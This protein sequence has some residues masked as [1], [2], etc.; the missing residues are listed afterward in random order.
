MTKTIYYGRRKTSKS[1]RA[2]NAAILFII[3]NLTAL[4]LY[5]LE[6]GFTI[7]GKNDHIKLACYTALVLCGVMALRRS[8]RKEKRINW[9]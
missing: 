9:I 3:A 4:V 7:V 8:L 2:E 6:N 1:E 5:I